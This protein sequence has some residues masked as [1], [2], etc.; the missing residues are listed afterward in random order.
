MQ[1]IGSFSLTG[2]ELGPEEHSWWIC[3][4]VGGWKGRMVYDFNHDFGNFVGMVDLQLAHSCMILILF[5]GSPH[6]VK[7]YTKHSL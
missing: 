5:S 1:G 6:I 4:W 7:R 3:G 2:R